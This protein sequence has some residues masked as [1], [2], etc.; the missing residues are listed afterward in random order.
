MV[1]GLDVWKEFFADYSANYVLIGGAACNIFEEEYAQTPRAT[2]DLDLILVVEALSKDF[3]N[4]F[5]DF[6]ISGNYTS[7]LRGEDKHEYYRFM[8][9]ENTAY[10]KQIELFARSTGLL[11]F[12]EDAHTEP[13]HIDDDLSSLSAILMDDDY[14]NFTI[15]HSI[16]IDGVHLANIEAL[17]CLKAKAFIDM[18]KRRSE[19]EHVDSR[20]IEKHKKDV[21]RLAAMLTAESRYILPEAMSKDLIDFC[22]AVSVELPNKDFL[23]SVGLSGMSAEELLSIIRG[24]FEL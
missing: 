19:G 21:L 14:Y 12:P 3:G 23:K 7:R 18:L 8:N 17:I 6:I 11:D 15:Q 16:T 2:K 10:P 9:P 13:I 20:D 1:K 5:W 24:A 22:N 4:K